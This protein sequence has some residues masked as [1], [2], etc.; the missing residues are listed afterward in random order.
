M[1]GK[2]YGFWKCV[3]FEEDSGELVKLKIGFLEIIEEE[4]E[5]IV[6]ENLDCIFFLVFD[7]KVWVLII[8]CS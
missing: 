1:V 5:E 4:L 8:C 3:F 2:M 7:V 6:L